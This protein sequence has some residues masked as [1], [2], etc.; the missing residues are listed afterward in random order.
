[1][2]QMALL[3]IVMSWSEQIGITS[4]VMKERLGLRAKGRQVIGEGETYKLRESGTYYPDNFDVENGDLT[5]GSA[6]PWRKDSHLASSVPC[7]AHT[8][9]LT[10]SRIFQRSGGAVC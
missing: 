4:R 5:F 10:G 1:M 7:P 9:R 3:G 6:I 8:A 2:M